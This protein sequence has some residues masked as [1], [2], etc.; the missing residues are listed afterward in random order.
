MV[1]RARNFTCSRNLGSLGPYNELDPFLIDARVL[2]LV[3]VKNY[4]SKSVVKLN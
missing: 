4:R 3:N 1:V 2:L